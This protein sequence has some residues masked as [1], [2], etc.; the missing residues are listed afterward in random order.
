MEAK[1]F[2]DR[3]SAR[4]ALGFDHITEWSTSPYKG[5]YSQRLA[6][7]SGVSQKTSD[8]FNEIYECPETG[9]MIVYLD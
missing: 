1:M 6:A 5:R 4:R 9:Q 2:N 7:W 3:D 8:W